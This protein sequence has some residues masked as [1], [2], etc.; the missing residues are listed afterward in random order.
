M[1]SLEKV[2]NLIKKTGDKCIILDTEGNPG[3]L[4]MTLKDYEKLLLGKRDLENLTEDE[5]L[6]RIN[7]DV[8]VWRAAQEDEKLANWDAFQSVLEDAKKP[9]HGVEQDPKDP[10]DKLLNKPVEEQ[11]EVEDKYYFE[12]VE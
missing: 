4:V 11:I 6:D 12:P 1:N 5:L 2:L 7:R 3:Y 10:F 8:A 9:L